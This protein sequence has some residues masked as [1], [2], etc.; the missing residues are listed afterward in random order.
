MAINY[1]FVRRKEINLKSIWN[2]K[3]FEEEFFGLPDDKEKLA[4]K[5][6]VK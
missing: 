5:N 4:W 2:G 1:Q 3:R 6:F